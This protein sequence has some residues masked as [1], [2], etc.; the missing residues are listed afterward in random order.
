M[1]NHNDKE[2]Y[3]HIEKSMLLKHWK[4]LSIP[5]YAFSQVDTLIPF[6]STF[7]LLFTQISAVFK[8]IQDHRTFISS[9]TWPD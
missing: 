4:D 6:R 2:F 5:L 9:D 8:E 1:S 7:R 3:L